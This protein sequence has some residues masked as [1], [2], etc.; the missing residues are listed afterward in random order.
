MHIACGASVSGGLQRSKADFRS[1]DSREMG[2]EKNI[3]ARG[4]GRGGDKGTPS[5][6]CFA[7]ALTETLATHAKMHT[8][9]TRVSELSLTAP[10][11]SKRVTDAK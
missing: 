6:L 2:R 3:D 7:L 9:V 1:L 8:T 4:E 11:L 10:V 5:L